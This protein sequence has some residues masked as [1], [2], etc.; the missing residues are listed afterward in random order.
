MF[1]AFFDTSIFAAL[2]SLAAAARKT[3]NAKY[4]AAQTARARLAFIA[5]DK[6]YYHSR[7]HGYHSRN[8]GDPCPLA[9]KV[10]R[11]HPVPQNSEVQL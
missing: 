9:E 10:E 5:H 2:R 3:V 4:F 6:G 11:T 8:D 7:N 1:R